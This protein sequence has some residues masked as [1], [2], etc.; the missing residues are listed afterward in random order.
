MNDSSRTAVRI[1]IRGVVQGVGFRPFVYA[2]AVRYGLRGWVLNT[3]AGVEVLAEGEPGAVA[4]FA[5][6][7][8]AE[9]PPRS[10]IAAYDVRAVPP[11]RAVDGPAAGE[12]FVILESR[13]DPGAYQLVSPDI[14][15]CDDCRRELLDAGDRRHGYP[16]TNCTNCG[17]RFTIIEDLPYDRRAD[18]DAALPPVPGVP[19]GVRGSGRPALPRRAQR[20]PRVRAAR[21]AAA[22][23][24]GGV[25]GGGRRRRRRPGGSRSRGRGTAPR[26]ARSSPSRVSAAFTSP[27]TPPTARWC[28][29]SSCASGAPTSR[30]R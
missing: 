29:A 23:E 1:S 17:P 21:T 27:A 11:R 22:P 24:T 16:F 19:A 26:A 18:H 10:H 25:V 5:E 2:L 20:V 8:P 15:T 4:G 14:A 7:L 28:A 30:W 6:A 9:A 3:S 12:G 13:A